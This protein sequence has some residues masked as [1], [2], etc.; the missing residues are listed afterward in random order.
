M[1]ARSVLGFL[2][3]RDSGLDRPVSDQGGVLERVNL[4]GFS[5]LDGQEMA[6][7]AVKTTASPGRGVDA[8]YPIMGRESQFEGF[9]VQRFGLVNDLQSGSW[10]ASVGVSHEE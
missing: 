3:F 5:E 2:D 10:C 9:D 1:S 6:F 7:V 4:G 8:A